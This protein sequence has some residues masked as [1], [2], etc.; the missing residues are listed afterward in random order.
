MQ[1][2]EFCTAF[3]NETWLHCGTFERDEWWT[4]LGS[5]RFML[6]PT[7]NGVQSPKFLEALLVGTIP[8]CQT[9]PAFVAFEAQGWPII[10]VQDWAEVLIEESRERW[11]SSLSP[12][13]ARLRAEGNFT[14]NG[15][16]SFIT[17]GILET[18]ETPKHP[19]KYKPILE[20]SATF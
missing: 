10:I 20:N 11:W 7:G 19:I 13:L 12:R 18:D 16:H 9:E 5:Y 17:P 3:S 1:A 14:A 4:R 8:I 6:N 2:G 15:C